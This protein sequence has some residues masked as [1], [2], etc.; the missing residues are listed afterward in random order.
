MA[1]TDI[2]T[3]EQDIETTDDQ[4]TTVGDDTGYTREKQMIDFEKANARKAREELATMTE[5]FEEASERTEQL[6]RELA[7]LKTSNDA[8]QRKL[9]V[10]QQKLEEMDPDLVD[11]K[12]I[13]NIQQLQQ[14]IRDQETKFQSEKTELVSQLTDLRTKAGTYE[15]ER[16]ATLEERRRAE[17]REKVLSRVERSLDRQGIKAAGKYRTEAHKLADEMVDSGQVP[18]PKD[19]IDGIELMETCYLKVHAKHSKGKDK[20]V[21]VDTG[22]SGVAV[23]SAKSGLKPGSL[24]DVYDQMLN[25]TS[26]LK[27]PD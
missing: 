3:E 4:V 15:Q 21:S 10:E 6:Q 19:V 8:E 5:A 18:Q 11:Q 12:V 25:D 14:Q 7:Q 23:T 1:E 17:V 24:D 22:K 13:K 2:T 20:T 26:W 27:E 16:A 9:Q